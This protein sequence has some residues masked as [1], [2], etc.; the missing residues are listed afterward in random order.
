MNFI[1]KNFIPRVTLSDV[2]E[3]VSVGGG[4]VALT[5]DGKF[6]PLLTV[7]GKF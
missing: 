7:D 3:T 5:V 2:T 1:V 6:F 4:G